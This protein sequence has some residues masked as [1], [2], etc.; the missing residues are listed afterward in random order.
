MSMHDA[1]SVVIDWD[2]DETHLLLNPRMPAGERQRLQKLVASGPDLLGHVWLDTSGTTGSLKLSALS[3]RAILASAKSVNRHLDA[4]RDDVWC[5]VLPT[6]HVGGLGIVAR[7]YLAGSRVVSAE[8]EARKFSEIAE[9][10]RVTLSALVPAQVRDLVGQQ[11]RAPKSIR[12]IVVGGGAMADDLYKAARDL[13]WPVLPSYGLTETAS[14]VATATPQSPDMHVLGHVVI[15][16]DDG[17]IE[18]R[19]ASLLTGYAMWDSH[20]N[21]VFADPKVDGWFITEDRGELI[22]D[23]LRVFGRA[24]ELVKVGG[25]SVDLKRLDS[26]LDAVR[27]GIDAAVIAVPDERLGH[28]VHLAS[29]G[30]ADGIVDAFNARVHP[31]E[32]IRATHRVDTIPRSPLGKLLRSKLAAL[33]SSDRTT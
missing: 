18:I 21:P 20:G 25:E 17:L 6:F 23:V 33:V 4:Q 27:G 19:G 24:G 7:A 32:R 10:E 16:I 15:R 29:T 26:V 14:Q 11:L 12:A 1:T 31:F 13:G 22:G 8:W 28:V 2:S 30:E 3:K 9:H 5:R